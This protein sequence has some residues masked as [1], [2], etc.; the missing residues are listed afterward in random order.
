MFRDCVFRFLFVFFFGRGRVTIFSR[1]GAWLVGG[2][3]LAR[4]RPFS[5]EILYLH[6]GE[7]SRLEPGVEMT[8]PLKAAQRQKSVD[9]PETVIYRKQKNEVRGNY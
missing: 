4:V 8:T 6:V 1:S 3:G 5:L 9:S 2:C 7:F